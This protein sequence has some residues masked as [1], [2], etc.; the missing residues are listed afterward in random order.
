MRTRLAIAVLS[1][2]AALP[3][4]AA[5]K[6]SAP[7][8]FIVEHRLSIAATPAQAWATLAQPAR[9]WPKEHTWSGNPANLS[10]SLTLGGC[11]CER[12]PDGGAEHGH[13]IMLKR[14]ELVRMNA[15]LGP[16]Q[17]MAVTGVLSIAITPKDEGSEAVVTYRVSGTPSHALDK[18]ATA[19]DQV[20]GLQFGSWAAMDAGAAEKPA[21]SKKKP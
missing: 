16:L 5:V 4:A 20:I 7:D 10:L 2:P 3:A 9:W 6:Q 15:A 12:W 17:D 11:F 14:N 8:G 21:G 13:V 18:L 19:V 1:I